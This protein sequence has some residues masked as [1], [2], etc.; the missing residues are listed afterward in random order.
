MESKAEEIYSINKTTVKKGNFKHVRTAFLNN[1]I[2]SNSLLF[3][4]AML[5]T[6]EQ[7]SINQIKYLN[8]PF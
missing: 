5:Q 1:R 6:I 2:L 3:Y 8:S 7:K 4:Q